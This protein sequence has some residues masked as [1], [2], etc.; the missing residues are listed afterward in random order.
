MKNR[1][2]YRPGVIK[3]RQG[4][5]GSGYG[6]HL[7]TLEELLRTQENAAKP[8]QEWDAETMKALRDE[9]LRRS[10]TIA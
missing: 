10:A 9:I 1:R 5:A 8:G 6:F 2:K 7:M 3:S 4:K